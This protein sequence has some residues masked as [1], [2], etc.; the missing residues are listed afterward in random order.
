MCDT[1]SVVLLPIQRELNEKQAQREAS[2]ER[3]YL[4]LMVGG[5]CALKEIKTLDAPFELAS[6][7]ENMF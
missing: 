3:L 2:R 4:T 7:S 6:A 5:A 1:R